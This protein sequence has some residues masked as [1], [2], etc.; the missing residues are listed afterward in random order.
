VGLIITGFAFVA[1]NGR[2]FLPGMNGIH[3]DAHIAAY[4][5]LTAHVHAAGA[6][7]AMQ[8]VH[9]GRQ[10]TPETIG[11]RPLAPSAVKDKAIFAR[12]RAMSETDILRVIE[13]FGQAARRARQSGFDAVQTHAAPW[14]FTG[15][16]IP[17]DGGAPYVNECP[18]E[19]GA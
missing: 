1:E 5:K 12:P 17:W 11:A 2:G 13:D 3:T 10:T 14:P 6:A 19:R 16:A 7:I 15:R 9:A 18:P 8:I 4:R